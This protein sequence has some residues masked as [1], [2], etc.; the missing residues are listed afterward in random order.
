MR[1]FC[2]VL[3]LLMLL[4]IGVQ[5]NDSDGAIW[6]LYYAIPAI[7]AA[8]AAF[9]PRW[10]LGLQASWLLLLSIAAAVVGVFY[11]WPKT[12]QWWAKD[13]WWE[14]ETAREGMGMMIVLF[15]LLMVLL[16][17]TLLRKRY[18]QAAHKA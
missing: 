10:L 1:V 16:A 12:P 6:M 2:G 11:Y 13:V 3:S 9:K 18:E 4:F 8:V 15:V 5:Y 7:A 14:T 17:R